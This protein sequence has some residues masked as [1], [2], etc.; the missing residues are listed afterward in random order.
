MV[1]PTLPP[2]PQQ[3]REKLKDHPELI[4]RLQ[5]ALNHAAKNP[6]KVTPPFELAIWE[7]ED[8]LSLFVTE[9]RDELAA[10]E[11]NGNPADI[12]QAKAKELLMLH[13]SSKGGWISDQKLWDYFQ[14]NGKASKRM[15]QQITCSRGSASESRVAVERFRLRKGSQSDSA[16]PGRCGSGV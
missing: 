13:A 5:D 8:T 2:V 10:V 7:L 11:A 12:E 6:S 1:K 9:A 3:L 15:P 4:E 14:T 16:F